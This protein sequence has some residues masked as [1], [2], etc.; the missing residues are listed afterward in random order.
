M[1]VTINAAK[2]AEIDRQAA[3]ADLDEW[4]AEECRVGI[5]T[6][7]GWRMKMDPESVALYTGNYVLAKASAD[8]GGVMPD[9]I[10]ADGQ[11]HAMANIE[12]LTAIMLVYGQSRALLSAEYKRKK[13]EIEAAGP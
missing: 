7:D 6:A 9:I 11:P 3:L 4:F 8:M 10:D 13:D 5:T 1:S 2:K 12:E